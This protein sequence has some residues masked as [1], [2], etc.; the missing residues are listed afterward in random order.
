MQ[1]IVGQ[2]GAVA[3]AVDLKQRRALQRRVFRFSAIYSSS[4]G[5]KPKTRLP[6]RQGSASKADVGHYY[7]YDIIMQYLLFRGSAAVAPAVQQH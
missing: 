4:I 5:L 7:Y 1:K 3:V 2:Q 6:T